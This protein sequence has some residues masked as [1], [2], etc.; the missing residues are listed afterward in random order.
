MTYRP[1][2]DGL[3][4]VAV[5]PV[6]LFHLGFPQFSGGFVGVDVFFVISGFLIT[7]LIKSRVETGTFS[8]VDFYLRRARRLLPALYATLLLS[9][10]IGGFLLSPAHLAQLGASAH[11]AALSASNVYFWWVGG[12]FGEAS[13]FQPL[14]HTWS[15]SVEEQFYFVWPACLVLLLRL[16]RK[17]A[18]PAGIAA[19]SL[20]SLVL[21]EHWLAEDPEAA[22]FLLPFRI[23]EFGIGAALVWIRPGRPSR[24]AVEEGTL[25]LGLALIGA[26]VLFYSEATPFPGS[27]A[28]VP[29][30]GAALALYGG[31]ARKVG[32]VL[33][34]PVAAGIGRISYSLYL[35]HWPIIVFYQYYRFVEM[36]AAERLA[37]LGASLALAWAMYRFVEHPFRYGTR[38]DF[39]RPRVAA[40]V[41][42][43]LTLAALLLSLTYWLSDGLPSRLP[44]QNRRWLDQAEE[45]LPGETLDER[46]ARVKGGGTEPKRR[47]LLLGD[48]HALAIWPALAREVQPFGIQL[49]ALRGCFPGLDVTR[50]LDK[51]EDRRCRKFSAKLPA[52]LDRYDGV[53]MV[54]RWSLYTSTTPDRGEANTRNKRYVLANAASIRDRDFSPERSTRVIEESLTATLEKLRDLGKPVLL[55][56][57]VPPLGIDLRPC[58]ARRSSSCLP[59]YDREEV[60]ERLGPSNDFLKRLS[61]KYPSSVFLNT[62]EALCDPSHRYCPTV[63]AGS[64]LYNDDDHLSNAGAVTIAPKLRPAIGTFARMLDKAIAAAGED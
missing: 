14:L 2:I 55:L 60:A 30:L 5:L 41:V 53:I 9:L 40:F 35:V 50:Y 28:L 24:T 59:L 31:Q 57:Q 54:A 6:V 13:I 38:L 15:L 19:A 46:I 8:Y 61:A 39:R 29:C 7:G 43:P 63:E 25:A 11:S 51:R 12:Y 26:A 36:S 22:F 10:C 37:L 27:A 48:S 16:G 49:V 44:E 47:V 32:L 20:V 18:A 42:A 1:D 62:F 64:F 45:R 21:A 33:R 23:A 58:L 34:N 4:T 3:R 56:G 52:V 17:W